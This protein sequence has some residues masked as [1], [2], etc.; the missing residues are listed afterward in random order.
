MSAV[1]HA[2]S[3]DLED[4]YAGAHLLI[5]GR[6][7]PPSEA[8]VQSARQLLELF[9]EYDAKATWFVLGDVAE[10]YP[11]LIRSIADGG[12]ELGIHGYH[13]H[14][15]YQLSEAKFRADLARAKR[16]VEDVSGRPVHGYR[17]VE[18]SVPEDSE[19][20]YCEVADAG[21]TYSSSVF[22]FA[23]PRF[24]RPSSPVGHHPVSTRA[25]VVWEVPLTVFR[26][27][28]YRLPCCGGGYLRHA[29]LSYTAAAL[30]RVERE[31]R[32]AVVYVHPYELETRVRAEFF[33]RELGLGT[34]LRAAKLIAAQLRGRGSMVRKLRWLLG[35]RAFGCLRDVFP[36]ITP[37]RGGR[38][39]EQT[40]A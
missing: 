40:G 12:H 37:Q 15:L 7:V 23:H 9:R 38:A 30:S 24:G 31:Q 25:G 10:A 6:I 17:A 1:R 13:H 22:P 5:G 34:S 18:F 8:V 11:T 36:E 19:R 28:K 33:W 27:W 20:F 32:P 26:F 3:V 4:W 39:A 2:L 35:T 21:L 16:V 14:R 29:P